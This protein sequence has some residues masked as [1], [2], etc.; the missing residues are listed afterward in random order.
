MRYIRPNTL[1][2]ATN[3]FASG[4]FKILAG[5]TDL[6]PALKDRPIE[7]DILDI[8]RI[9]D[10]RG[11]RKTETG[12]RIGAC[13]T[14]SDI[15]RAALP[16]CFGGLQMAAREIGS[17]QIQNVGTIGGN[18]CNASP[19]ADSI[20]PLLTLDAVVDIATETGIRTL[21]L[22]E[23]LLGLR[24]TALKPNE[25]VSAIYIPDQS[26]Y[27]SFQKIGA[28]KFLVI[29]IAMVAI[30]LEME[31]EQTIKSTRIAI[32]SCSPVAQRMKELELSLIGAKLNRK[33]LSARVEPKLFQVLSPI[34]DIRGDRDYR[35]D[36]VQEL[37]IRLLMDCAEKA[38]GRK[39]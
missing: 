28:R 18:L 6:Y 12:W 15:A 1:D 9:P 10:I 31:S 27:S 21:E 16:D 39:R 26:G 25:F 34:D 23:F 36:A 11:I 37:V 2:E 8:S 3:I 33:T 7:A 20:P 29:S 17:I 24:K 35:L 13:T 32:G 14:W 19:A 5:G 4:E 22:P 38:N 30:V